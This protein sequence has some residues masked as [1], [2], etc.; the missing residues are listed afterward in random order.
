[1]LLVFMANISAIG[2]SDASYSSGPG[3][4]DCFISYLSSQ[5]QRALAVIHASYPC[6]K[7]YHGSGSIGNLDKKLVSSISVSQMQ[8]ARCHLSGAFRDS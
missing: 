3:F 8:Y 7:D 2:W 4:P 1:M 6:V 5:Q